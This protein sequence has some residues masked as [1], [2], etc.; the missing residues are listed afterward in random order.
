MT[1]QN[2][3]TKNDKRTNDILLGPL[4]RPALQFFARNMPGWVNSD[5][6][7]VLGL[8]GSVLAGVAYAMVGMGEIKGNPWLFVASLG[9]FINWFGDSLDGTLARFRH[10]E[11]PNYGFYT[12][13]AIDGITAL[14]IFTAI[15]LS[16]I[17]RLDISI[18]ALACWLLLMIQVYLKTHVTG[19]FEM[20]S[21]GVGPTEV[22]LFVML[23]NTVLF[24][25]GIGGY[26]WTVTIKGIEYGFT[27][28]SIIVLS[29]ALLFLGYFIYQVMRTAI[30]LAAQDEARL[31][32]RLAKEA[33]K[34]EKTE[35]K[36]AKK[37]RK[38]LKKE[39][40][41]S[42]TSTTVLEEKVEAPNP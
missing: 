24:F 42:K 4:E 7:T 28:G 40:A 17:A 39:L 10:H 26:I 5:M 38:Q 16:G 31:V 1:N 33:R 20:T 2:D 22:R 15:G 23:L 30:T 36:A 32:K 37:M 9:F 8:L 3:G 6:L 19:T 18:F 14:I 21:I 11:R 34:A 27:I 41:K 12:D 13:H 35:Q 29:A 25:T